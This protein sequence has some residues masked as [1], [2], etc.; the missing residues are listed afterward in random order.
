VRLATP[1]NATVT[2]WLREAT[3]RPAGR[4]WMRR[5]MPPD[6]QRCHPEL[7]DRLHELADQLPGTKSRYVM[8]I[9]LL[10]HP[11]DVV[12]AVAGGQSWI[13]FRLPTHVHTAVVRSE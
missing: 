2:S 11:G 4:L 8:G 10:V 1:A 5:R 9:P 3:Q 12:F 13:S 7:F 6:S